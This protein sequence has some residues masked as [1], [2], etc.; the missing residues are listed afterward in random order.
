MM[1]RLILIFCLIF[2][3]LTNCFAG[4]IAPS[5]TTVATIITMARYYLNDEEDNFW[6]DAELLNWINQ[7]TID[8]VSR[9]Q[10]L[11]AI[12]DDID[13]IASTYEYTMPQDYISIS[14]IIYVDSDG[15][16]QGLV[17]RD[18]QAIGDIP[19]LGQPGWWYEWAGK[20]GIYPAL[21]AVTSENIIVYYVSRPA[22]LTLTTEDVLVPAQYDNALILYVVAQA[23]FKDRMFGSYNQIIGMYQAELDRYRF[24]LNQFIQEKI[25]G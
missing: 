23:M 3:S 9:S 11:T 22:K 8:I 14:K 10:C 4:N 19:A 21:A 20:I 18:M 6:S 7:G 12:L 13:L 16:L 1:K 25:K 5:E 2:F 17:K 15:T 24:D